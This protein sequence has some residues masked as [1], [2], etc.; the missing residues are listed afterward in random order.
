MTCA[1]GLGLMVMDEAFD[2]WTGAK[3]KWIYGR[4]NGTAGASRLF[5]IF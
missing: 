2:E 4:N 3:N 1:I 5:G